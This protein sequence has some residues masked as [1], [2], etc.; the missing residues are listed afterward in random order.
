MKIKL[1]IASFSITLLSCSTPTQYLLTSPNGVLQVNILNEGNTPIFTAIHAGDTILKQSA[2]GL[3]VNETNFTENVSF[4]GFTENEFDETW[5]TIN[6]KQPTVRNHYNEYTF[7]IRKNGA[8]PQFHEII[9]RLYDKGFAYRY[10]FPLDA[11]NDSLLIEKELTE[12]NFKNDFNYWAYNGENHNLGPILRSQKSID[13]VRTPIVLQLSEDNFI[14]IHEAEIIDFVPF[15]INASVKDQALGFN[16]DYSKRKEPFKTSW[17]AFILGNKPGDLVESNLLVN[18]NE[19]CQIKDPLWI[20]P[21]KSLWDWRVWGY[22]TEDGFEYGLN[23]ISHKRFIDFAAENNIQYLL[24][25]ADWYGDEFNENSDPTTSKEGVDIE[26]CMRYAKEKGVGIILYLNDVGAKKFGLERVIKQFSEWGA[27]GVKYGFMRGSW[28]DKV[29]HTRHVVEL[30]ARYKLMVN[31][32]DNPVPP[33]GDRRTY[34]NLVTKEFGHSQ[35]DAKKSY[36][37]EKAVTSPFVNMIAGPLDMCNGWFDLNR[38][39][40]RVKV[41]EEIPGTVA[42]EVAKLIVVYTGWM[43]LPDSPEEY[44]EKEDLFDCIRKMPP[45]FDSFKVL[46]GK[47][48][49]YISVARQAGDNWFIGSLTNREARTLEID[50]NFLPKERVYAATIYED[51]DDSHFLNNKEDYQIR[52][53]NIDSGTKLKIK[54]AAGGGC[55]IY[56]S[57]VSIDQII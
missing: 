56:L 7:K 57:F 16:I 13:N 37:P 30:C 20:K 44:L 45:Q 15:S 46:D 29:R 5:T 18:L 49:E 10:N 54:L 6:G 33:S 11:V 52:K 36:F 35:A 22:K 38:T 34:P 21:G 26:E 43:I 48:G 23:T 14:A 42:A 40:S 31:F 27:I 12:L 4:T 1:F 25:D 51:A 47:I 55:A 8:L 9:F 28:E 2:L 41:F 17:R 3:Q 32:H 53:V 19:P 39:H 50:F 24:I